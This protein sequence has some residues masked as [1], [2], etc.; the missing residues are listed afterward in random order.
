VAA[1]PGAEYG[2][3]LFIAKGCQYCHARSGVSNWVP[4]PVTGP[5]V[6]D[7]QGQPGFLR[8]WLRDPQIMRPETRM[9]NLD[10]DQAEIEALILF[11]NAEAGAVDV[12]RD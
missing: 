7:Y 6:T 2:R 9:P 3:A 8:L 12:A 4:G 1:A 11:L 10:L 5:N